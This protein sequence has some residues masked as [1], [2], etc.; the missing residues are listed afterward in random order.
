MSAPPGIGYID[1]T[2]RD[3]GSPPWGSAIS[4]ED[5]AAAASAL[6]EARPTVLE[7]LDAGCAR[8]ALDVRAESPWDRLRTVVRVV[9]DI[10]VG[11]VIGGQSLWGERPLGDDLIER[12]V[13]GARASGVARI[14]AFD[15]LNDPARLAT[16]AAATAAAGMRF[17][18]TLI[19]GPAPAAGDG[20]WLDEAVGLAALPGAVALCVSERAGHFSPDELAD[21]IGH[22]RERIDL[23]IEVQVQ[24]PGGIAPVAA[25]AA[26]AGGADAVQASAGAVALVAARP[27]T[28]TLRAA[29]ASRPRPFAC[30]RAG[31]DG[32]GR[33][34]SSL[35]PP[36]RL[37]RAAAAVYGAAVGLPPDLE[38][39]LL[40]RLSRYSMA[41]RVVEAAVEAAQ[42]C[43]ELGGLTFSHPLA[44]AIVTQ[45]ATHVIEG[46]RYRALEP[47]LAEAAL[48]RRGRLRGP[49]DPDV[50]AAAEA[51]G[52]E[53][54]PAP[55]DLAG[56]RRAGPASV[57]EEDLVL[58]AQ[59]G[60]LVDPLIARRRS[61]AAE[62]MEGV[63]E[64]TVD[65]AL[66]ETL[67]NVVEGA[68]DAEV[69]V[70]VGGA[71]I[72]VRRSGAPPVAASA[73]GG[74]AGAPDPDEGLI[75]VESPMVG[76]FYRSPS[77]EAGPFVTEGQRVEIGQTL[78]LVEAMKLFNEIT[79]EMAGTV[80]RICV[81]NEAPVEFGQILFA[82][83]P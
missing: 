76:T 72:T 35:I 2:L 8:A 61:L 23:P 1:A 69:S 26:I 30:D 59:F 19:L 73:A 64:S 18:P 80:R 13:L 38:A 49:V 54:A 6:A 4:P 82:I 75:R 32:A 58:W 22:I 3:L 53:P 14:R 25:M 65:R 51:A 37:R 5:L 39:G 20:R 10:P 42:V 55:V 52:L 71:R 11:I 12:F 41:D 43:A 63:E 62:T 57:S 24:A 36:D 50:L 70:E 29:L 33:E 21:L 47:V 34:L 45:A 78:C 17:V 68:G 74:A 60:A 15:P 9:G 83:E 7:A 56:A 28:E 67:V 44:D 79:A 48:G 46:E 40:W 66:L 16:T 77:P 31:V 27:S 81:D